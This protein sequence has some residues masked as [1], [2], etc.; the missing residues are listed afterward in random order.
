MSQK[1]LTKSS[2]NTEAENVVK[3]NNFVILITFEARL[4]NN[5][6][7]NQPYA[8]SEHFNLTVVLTE[9]SEAL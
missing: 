3:A 9:E 1:Y 5:P 4:W 6:P 7:W 2:K 8:L